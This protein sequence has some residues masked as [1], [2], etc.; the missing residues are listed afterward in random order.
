MVIPI[1]LGLSGTIANA[2]LFRIHNQVHI[3]LVCKFIFLR[4]NN[5]KNVKRTLRNLRSSVGT[6]SCSLLITLSCYL[7]FICLCAID[8]V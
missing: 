2:Y 6:D 5:Y 7:I 4:G 8:T 3:F 1:F